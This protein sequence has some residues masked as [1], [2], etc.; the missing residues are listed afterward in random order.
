MEAHNGLTGLIAEKIHIKSKGKQIE[1]DGI[2]E[3]SLTDSTSKGKPD[4]SIVDTTSR[5]HSIQE[6]LEVTTKPIIFDGDNG[7]RTEHFPYTVRSLE[8]SGISATVIEDKTGFKRNSLFEGNTDQNQDSIDDF[9]AKIRAGKKNQITKDFMIIARIESFIL[10]K[11]LDDALKRAKAYL[12]AGADGILIHSK[13]KIPDEVLSFAKI[14][15]SFSKGMPLVVVPSTYNVITEGELMK[16]G[17]RIVIHANHL[18]R[19]A[20]PAMVNVAKLILKHGRSK[21][22]DELC[23]PINDVINLIP[24]HS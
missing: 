1:F 7:G 6:I 10:N 17:I 8:R 9:S 15:K 5:L 16:A 19:S 4:T 23:L 11:G 13:Q 24:S 21:E 12:R 18:I 2:W 22:A 20:Y 3:S 14:Y